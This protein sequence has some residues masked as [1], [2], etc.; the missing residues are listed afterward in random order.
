MKLERTGAEDARERLPNVK[1]I[2]GGEVI[3]CRTYGRRNPFCT[4]ECWD[5]PELGSWEFSWQ[6]IAQHVATGNPLRV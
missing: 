4:V 5:R 3:E 6:A 2:V 1:V